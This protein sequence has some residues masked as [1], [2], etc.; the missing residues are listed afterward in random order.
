MNV[1]VSTDSGGRYTGQIGF[2]SPVAEFTP[3]SVQTRELRTSLVYR[4]RVVVS[5]ADNGLRQGMPVTVHVDLAA[6][7]E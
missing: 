6:N 5:E 2:I 3:R 7:D 1:T 4:V